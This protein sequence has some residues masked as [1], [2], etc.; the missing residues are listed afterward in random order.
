MDF[1]A[2]DTGRQAPEKL[3]VPEHVQEAIRTLIRWSGDNPEREGL[4]DTP[5]RVA[6]AW[7][8]YCQGY[9]RIRR[10]I[11]AASSPKSAATMKWCC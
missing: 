11:S 1:D 9:G 8:E 4:L 6:R 10:S 7:S 3:P 5:A 2:D